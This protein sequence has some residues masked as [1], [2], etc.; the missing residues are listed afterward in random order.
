M[1]EYIVSF[2][3]ERDGFVSIAFTS[4]LATGVV[5]AIYLAHVNC[6]GILRVTNVQAREF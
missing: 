4:F 5:N 6:M 2:E 1:V 3:C